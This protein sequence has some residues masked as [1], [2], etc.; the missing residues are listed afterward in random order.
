MKRSHRISIALAGTVALALV[1]AYV[2]S[3]AP[4]A[5]EPVAQEPPIA[6]SP[7]ASTKAAP[8]ASAPAS[9]ILLDIP[10]NEPPMTAGGIDENLEKLIGRSAMRT[11]VQIDDFPRRFVAT[12]DNLGR[13]RASTSLWPVNP[14]P[15]RFT[16][17]PHDGAPLIAPD[18][19]LR[20]T[21]FVV[22]AE[23]V[24]IEHAVD[25]YVRMY[26]LLQN[27]YEGLGFPNR[28]FND[29]LVEVIDQL[30]ATP[31]PT[32]PIRLELPEIKGPVRSERPWVRYQFADPEL[33]ALSAGQK[34]LIRMGP[35]NERR[36]KV[37]LKE[38]RQRI[39]EHG[40]AR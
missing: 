19:G 37:K 3:T 35:D 2:R 27:A 6:S 14:T 23:T 17:D 1:I 5:A 30:L 22:L 12:V 21:P 11:F 24:N 34:T 20:Y 29:R 39:V 9:S 25:L 8:P 33:E 16:V 10:K 7:A 18:N 31:E 36:L 28:Y 32:V 40:L 15:G 38:I 4:P 26:P 13:E